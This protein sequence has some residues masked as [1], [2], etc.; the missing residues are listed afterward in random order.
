MSIDG[1]IVGVTITLENEFNTTSPLPSL[2]SWV[3]VFFQSEV[4]LLA[5][6]SQCLYAHVAIFLGVGGSNWL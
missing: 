3:V 5:T 1:T 4:G 2:M 6:N